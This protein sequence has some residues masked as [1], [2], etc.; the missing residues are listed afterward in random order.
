M[1]KFMALQKSLLSYMEEQDKRLARLEEKI[2]Q[3]QGDTEV[4]DS[5]NIDANEDN[6]KDITNDEDEK[7]V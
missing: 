2:S 3:I 5:N 7:E 6:K 4:G 1:D